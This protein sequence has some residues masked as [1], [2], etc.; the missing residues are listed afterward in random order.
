MY[1]NGKIEGNVDVRDVQKA[2]GTSKHFWN[3]L[4]THQN[5]NPMAKYKPVR[6]AKKEDLQYDDF[7][8]SHFGF[9]G[10]VPTF[11]SNNSNPNTAWTYYKPRGEKTSSSPSD[12]TFDEWYRI[13]DFENYDNR[14]AAPFDFEVSG[15]IGED[16]SVGIYFYVN[17]LAP[18][19]QGSSMHWK[20]DT[21]LSIEE[22]LSYYN[23]LAQN[24][25]LVVCIHDVSGKKSGFEMIVTS[26]NPNTLPST[27]KEIILYPNGSGSSKPAIPIFTDVDRY[28]HEFRFIVGVVNNGPTAEG[29]YEVMEGSLKNRDVYSIAF[30]EG[31]DRTDV[32]LYRRGSIAGLI[33]T[34]LRTAITIEY[35]PNSG[36][37]TYNG[38]QYI[39]YTL[40]G[41]VFGDFKTPNRW[42]RTTVGISGVIQNARINPI[43]QGNTMTPVNFDWDGLVSDISVAK[44]TYNNK[45]LKYFSEGTVTV[46]FEKSVP[47]QYRYVNIQAWARNPGDEN[48]YFDNGSVEVYVTPHTEPT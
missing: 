24:P 16:G 18:S 9:G 15:D 29:S 28:G 25:H 32:A 2:L 40:K 1:N 5:I 39:K 46:Y 37:V 44:T 13:T 47:Q 20:S 23:T 48:V 41:T 30:E 19:H 45:Q 4:C 35:V 27:G 8:N 7:R 33:A 36:I 21:C 43:I 34:N 3:E 6:N 22:F 10:S 31:I 42:S 14:A 12:H 11:I 26:I 17:N 38:I